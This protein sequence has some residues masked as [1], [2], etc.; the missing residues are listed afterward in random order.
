MPDN[1]ICTIPVGVL[2]QMAVLPPWPADKKR[3]I[4][5]LTYGS[6]VRTTYQTRT[7]YW[8]REGLN[9]FGTSDAPFEVWSPTFGEPGRRG[10]LQ[11]FVYEDLARKLSAM[12]DEQR[13]EVMVGEMEKVHPGLSAHL[14]GVFSKCWDNDRWQRGAFTIYHP[15]EQVMYPLICR[16]EGRI[17]FAG[18]HA[19][20]WP[21]WMQGALISGM[22]A[23]REVNG[24]RSDCACDNPADG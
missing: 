8:E 21:G 15:H 24:L 3:V 6:V 11:A 2:R 4:D 23:A 13:E 22:R 12:E 16:P 19:S 7:R 9:G 18:E 10:L 17:L 1:V 5:S 14:E 20:P